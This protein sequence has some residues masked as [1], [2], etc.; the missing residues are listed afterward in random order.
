MNTLSYQKQDN[1][2][3]AYQAVKA[4]ITPETIQKFGVSAQMDYSD[5]NKTVK[6]KGKGFELTMTFKE[7]EVEC[8]LN[9]SFLLKPLR[10]KVEGILKKE[11]LKVI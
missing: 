9:L 7:K 4:G 5:A 10:S 11:L 8:D 2:E 1:A 3:G 6:A